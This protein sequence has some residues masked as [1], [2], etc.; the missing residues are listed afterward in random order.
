MSTEWS[1][2]QVFKLAPD[3]ASITAAKKLLKPSHWGDAGA[4]SNAIWGVC[5]GSYKVRIALDDVAFKCSCPS[6]KYPCKH[7][8]ALFALY[9]DQNPLIDLTASPPDWAADWLAD[10]QKRAE[11]KK[12]RAEKQADPEAQAKRAE[13]RDKNIRA[14]LAELG[15]WL[16]DLIRQGVGELPNKPYSFYENMAARLVDA[17]AAGLATWVRDLPSIV[18]RSTTW[19]NDV[20]ETLATL[21]LLIQAYEHLDQLP[22]ALQH[23]IR[24]MMG[25]SATKNEIIQQQPAITDQ[26][27]VVGQYIE[28][29]DELIGQRI[30]LRGANTQRTALLLNF[31]HNSSPVNTLDYSWRTGMQ[32]HA[33]LCFYPS[34][35][36]LR[37]VLKKQGESVAMHMEETGH[38]LSQALTDYKDQCSQQ[39]W[40][41][42]YPM[43]LTEVTP[44]S[45]EKQQWCFIDTN[46]NSIRISKEF[47]YLWELLALSGGQPLTVFGEWWKQQFLP[48]GVWFNQ[49]YHSLSPDPLEQKFS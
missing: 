43:L 15:L 11:K 37:A 10:R 41:G 12:V 36:P 35:Y 13:K 8:L 6:R 18:N 45:L 1:T 19:T 7:S 26:W 22:E 5:K 16:Q 46:K 25:W 29:I 24:S 31:M 30:W 14:G 4:D 44:Q 3:S 38:L 20:L 32:V 42:R 49:Q 9:A 33:E 28:P 17:Q 23:D 21:H 40:L 48:L 2:E 39:P 34:S 47:K 27:Q